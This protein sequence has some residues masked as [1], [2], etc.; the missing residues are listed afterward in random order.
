MGGLGLRS[1]GG[2]TSVGCWATAATAANQG[3]L[4]PAVVTI[5]K[6]TRTRRADLVGAFWQGFLS[7]DTTTYS[8][9]FDL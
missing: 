3:R 1:V 9:R 7:R 4:G 6:K 5:T 8:L 2:T